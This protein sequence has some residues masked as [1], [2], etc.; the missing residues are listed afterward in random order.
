[1]NMNQHP[2][3]PDKFA[4]WK[5]IPRAE[6]DWYPTVDAEKCIGCGMCIVSCGRN[7]FDYDPDTRT[8]VVARPLQC[9]VGCTSCEVWCV[10]E[11]ISFPDPSYVRQIIVKRKLLA[12]AREELQKLVGSDTEIPHPE[13][14]SSE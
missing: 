13:C 7:V 11:A 4:Y 14:D 2:Q 9:M 6:I 8:A 1:M 12:Q 10:C 3:L 5:G